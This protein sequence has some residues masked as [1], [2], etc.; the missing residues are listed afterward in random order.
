MKLRKLYNIFMYLLAGIAGLC[1]IG[2]SKPVFSE[3][4]FGVA[5][6]PTITNVPTITP[7]IAPTNT[8]TPT[9]TNTPTPSPTVTPTPT[10]TPTPTPSPTPTEVPVYDQILRFEA[11]NGPNPDIPVKAALLVNISEHKVLYAD[12][13]TEVIYPASIT[14]LMTAL[15]A[16][17]QVEDYEQTVTISKQAVTPVIPS[18]KMCGFKAGD[19][20]IFKDLL[21]CMLVYS[22]NDTSVAVAEHISGSEEEF[23]AVMNQKAKELELN[24]SYFCNSHGLPDDNHVTSAY[25]IYLIMQKLFNFEEFLGIIES[26]SITVDVLR[27]EST[28][29]T[30][31]FASTNQFLTGAYQVPEGITMLGGKTGTTNKAGCCL[32]IYV[33]DQNGDCY[34]AEIFGAESQEALYSSMIQL[35]SHI[36]DE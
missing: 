10:S 5:L 20:I 31:T 1:L 35:L 23:V 3:Q 32:S 29:K 22:G 18:A 7:T 25:D 15:V 17:S 26:G 19:K 2:C 36:S 30:F 21:G 27:G 33:K 11:E 4:D 28:L 34:I 13:A 6:S 24:S 14:K 12:K 8:P 16:F 9:L